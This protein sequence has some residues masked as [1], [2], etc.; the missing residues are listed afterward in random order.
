MEIRRRPL[1]SFQSR[2][3]TWLPGTPQAS[4]PDVRAGG[5]PV[6]A[7]PLLDALCACV[8]IINTRTMD[9]VETGADRHDLLR[10]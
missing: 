6:L 2:L 5:T 9:A 7:A 4:T 8:R 10:V 3:L 1:W